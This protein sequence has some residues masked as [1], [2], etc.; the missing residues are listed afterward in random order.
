MA[1]RF[2]LLVEGQDDWHVLSN[3]LNEHGVEAWRVRPSSRED[4]GDKIAV[5]AAGGE[6]DAKKGGVDRLLK[7]LAFQLQ[8]SD[9]ERVGIVVDADENLAARWQAVC[10]RI[11]R[12]GNVDLPGAP[13]PAGTVVTL[14]QPD[15]TLVVGVWLMPDNTD[16]GMIEDF[17]RFLVPEGDALLPRAERCLEAIP[18]NERLFAQGDADHTSKALMHTWLAWQDEPGRPLGQAVTHRYLDAQAPRALAF[19]EWAKRLFGR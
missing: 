15:R 16:D 18:E 10:T 3:L 5:E 14:E 17:L 9:Q 4:I 1:H 8:Q 13:D 2:R 19:V 6:E 12:A 11:G 7:D